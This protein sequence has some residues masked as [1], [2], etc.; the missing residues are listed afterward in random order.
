[1]HT[2]PTSGHMTSVQK[3]WHSGVN[4]LKPALKFLI[5]SL[6]VCFINEA[7]Q[8]FRACARALKPWLMHGTS[9]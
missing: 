2:E 4:A 1:M 3:P 9:S 6:N 7:E 8:N 5:S